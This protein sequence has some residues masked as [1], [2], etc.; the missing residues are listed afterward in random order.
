MMLHE[1]TTAAG[2]RP[3]RKRVGRGESS[4]MG[5]TC[6]RGNKGAQSRAGYSRKRLYES[7]QSRLFSRF[8]KRGFNNFNFRTEY[9][10]VN[11]DD[12]EAVFDAGA[13]VDVAALQSR[14]LVRGGSPRVKVLARG[15]ITKKLTVVAHAFS[16]PARQ[17][18]EK[19]GGACDVLP[20]I[21]PVARA[22]A[23]RKTAKG[24]PRRAR[25]TRLEKKKLSA[26][27]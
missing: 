26:R 11:L 20:R 16:E 6:G 15:D 18:I 8:P 27:S 4:G 3:R 5:R 10:T 7:G 19:A 1:I 13:R 12:L 2:A 22:K 17:A 9:V 14:R 24:T 25:P 21:D 23:K